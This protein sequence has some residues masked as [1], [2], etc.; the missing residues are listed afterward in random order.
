VLLHAAFS[1]VPWLFKGSNSSSARHG[2]LPQQSSLVQVQVPQAESGQ[3]QGRLQEAAPHSRLQLCESL[4]AGRTSYHTDTIAR[5]PTLVTESCAKGRHQ[6]PS[7]TSGPGR[8][9]RRARRAPPGVERDGA[10]EARLYGCDD[11]AVDGGLL[12]GY[13]RGVPAP[14]HAGRVDPLQVAVTLDAVAASVDPVRGRDNLLGERTEGC[15]GGVVCVCGGG[16]GRGIWHLL[17]SAAKLL[18]RGTGLGLGAAQ[19]GQLCPRPC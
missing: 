18:W 13:Q 5:R 6:R 8:Q 19:P 9:R 7:R 14:A 1:F 4:C 3:L 16:G 2:P 10:G 11:A 17:G 15:S 12:P